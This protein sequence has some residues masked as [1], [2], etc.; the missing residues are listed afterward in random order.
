VSVLQLTAH[1]EVVIIANDVCDLAAA[2]ISDALRAREVL[3]AD[4]SV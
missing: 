3:C 2:L 4:A 1:R